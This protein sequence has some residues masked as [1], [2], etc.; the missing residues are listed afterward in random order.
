MLEFVPGDDGQ[1]EAKLPD[2]V[3]PFKRS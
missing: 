1:D 2:N 3:V